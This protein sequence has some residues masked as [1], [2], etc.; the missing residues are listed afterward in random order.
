MDLEPR[1]RW[2]GY[3]KAKDMMFN[4]TDTKQ[5]AWFVVESDDKRRLRLNCI[6]HFIQQI[7]YQKSTAAHIT[8]PAIDKTGYV[9]SPHHQQTIVPDCY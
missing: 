2:A 6:H 9:R 7:P 3:S 1:S 5:I 8:L 4:Y